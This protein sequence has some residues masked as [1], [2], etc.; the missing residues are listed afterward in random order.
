MHTN[1]DIVS[2]F[3]PEVL[4]GNQIEKT[5]ER[6]VTGC[7]GAPAAPRGVTDSRISH[8]EA[9]R[10]PKAEPPFFVSFRASLWPL[11]LVRIAGDGRSETLPGRKAAQGR[12]APPRHRA[13]RPPLAL[14]TWHLLLPCKARRYLCSS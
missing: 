6:R 8:E 1:E 5:S 7:G 10:T 13:A 9:Q 14:G 12:A 2:R 11:A 3:I 4:N